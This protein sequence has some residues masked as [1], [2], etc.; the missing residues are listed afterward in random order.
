M[1]IYSK[2]EI[3]QELLQQENIANGE[4]ETGKEETVEGDRW[5]SQISLNIIEG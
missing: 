3:Y 1:K 2:P 4:N 5:L